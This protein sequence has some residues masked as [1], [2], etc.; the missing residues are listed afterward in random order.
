M[1]T[2]DDESALVER[3]RAG[4]PDAFAILLDRHHTLLHRLARR[5]VSSDAVADEVV[6]DTWLAVIRSID[7]FEGRSSVK[8]WLVSIMSNLAL[9]RSAQEARTVPFSSVSD[10]ELDLHAGFGIESFE[11]TGRWRGHWI[12]TA[13]GGRWQS[14]PDVELHRHELLDVVRSATTTLPDSQRQVFVLRDIDDWTAAEVS[15]ALQLSMANQRVL[16]HRARLRVRLAVADYMNG[17]ADG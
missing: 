3:L 17:P 15:D 4:D 11:A 7:R 13:G 8:T 2:G 12:S 9:R 6:A 5:F 14:T 16:L 1:T 10:D